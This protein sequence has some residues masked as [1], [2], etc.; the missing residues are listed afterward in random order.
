[1]QIIYC[2]KKLLNELGALGSK[3]P[4]GH[5]TGMFGPWHANLIRIKRKKCILFTND[6]TLYSFL[7]PGVKKKDDFHDL[8][9]MNLN[10]HLAGEGLRQGEIL[11]ALAEYSDIAIAPTSNRS[12]LGSM[13]DLVNQVE[14]LIHR[15]GGLEKADMLRVNMML[16]RVPM[17]ALKY[18]YAV[19]KVFELFGR[20][21]R[22][23]ECIDP[24]T[25]TF[26]KS[27][28]QILP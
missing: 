15:A 2:T 5:P 19:E 25:M 14:F 9:L 13:N 16:N 23:R 28:T 7:V 22:V 20:T 24:F 11:K 6:G 26:S 27:K 10:A 8:F 18:H 17:G 21:D 3:M 4:V 12:V 1:M